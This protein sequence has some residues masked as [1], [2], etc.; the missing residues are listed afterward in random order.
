MKQNQDYKNEALAALKGRWP[1]AVLAFL[2]YVVIALA[3][4]LPYEL[5]S[6]Q[7]QQD[8]TNLYLA[9]GVMKWYFFL[10]LGGIFVLGPLVV[11][12]ANCYKTLLAD[13]DERAAANELRWVSAIICTMCGAMSLQRYSFSSGLFFSLFLESSRPCPMR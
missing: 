13:G 6:L 4:A 11:G 1:Q 5:K 7:L 12:L 2:A 3:F 10:L 9:S 8:P